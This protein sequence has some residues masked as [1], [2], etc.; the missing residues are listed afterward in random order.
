MHAISEVNKAYEN[1][2]GLRILIH[3]YVPFQPGTFKL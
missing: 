3:E 1:E 2:L